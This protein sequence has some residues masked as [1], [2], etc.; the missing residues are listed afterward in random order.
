MNGTLK[1][2]CAVV[3]VA[4]AFSK[5]A[6]AQSKVA[7]LMPG[8]GGATPIDF[9]VRNQAGFGGAG[10]SVIVTTSSGE[11]ASISLSE[12]AKGRK[13]VFVGMS[14]GTIDVAN[15][16]AAGAKADGVVFVSGAYDKVRSQLGSPAKLP[17]ALIVH[18][19]RDECG[20]TPPSAVDSFVAWSAGKTSVRW[21]SNQGG[22]VPN[23]CGPR[24]AHGFYMQDGAAVS[25]INSFIR[26]R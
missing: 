15:A 18:H 24:G 10:V 1:L 14:R 25:A 19:R 26:S 13:V 20:A 17:P 11:A 23:P 9:L 6:L 3:S 12:A 5:P 4:M 2:F 16:V 21:I 8:A 7:I 22:A